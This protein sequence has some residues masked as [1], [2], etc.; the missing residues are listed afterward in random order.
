MKKV[1]F[2]FVILVIS[3]QFSCTSSSKKWDEVRNSYNGKELIQEIKE[4]SYVTDA[5]ITDGGIL[6]VASNGEKNPEMLASFFL[7]KANNENFLS[8]K[9][10]KIVSSFGAKRS[11]NYIQGK[12]LAFVFK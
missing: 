6:I 11:N 2:I 10:C 1:I 8:L 7:K 3:A 9:G 12:Q 4:Y 5:V